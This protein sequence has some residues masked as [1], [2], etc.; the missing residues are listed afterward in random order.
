MKEDKRPYWNDPYVIKV[1]QEADHCF[2]HPLGSIEEVNS[3]NQ[4]ARSL[5]LNGKWKFH[6]SKNADESV[7]KFYKSDYQCDDWDEISVPANWQMEGYGIP[8]YINKTYP[9]PKR[10]P[11]VDASYNPVGQYFRTFEI[12]DGWS[13]FKIFLNLEG[14]N[15]SATIWING[16]EVGYHQDSKTRA[17]FYITP[18]LK[19]GVNEIAIEVYRWCDGSYLE[20]QDFWRL[21]G[22]ERPIYLTARPKTYIQDYKISTLLKEDYKD[23]I[24]QAD[25]SLA[26]KT[27]L[28][29]ATYFVKCALAD[30]NNLMA[31]ALEEV[32]FEEGQIN[33]IINLSFPVTDP[34]KWTAETPELYDVI[35]SLYNG[36]NDQIEC[37]KAKVGFRSVEIKDGV[38]LV[39]GEYVILKGVNHHEH[40][41]DHGH[42]ISEASMIEDIL[43]MKK[44]NINAVRNSH[45]PKCQRWYELCDVYGL[46]IVDEANIEAHA[47]GARFQDEYDESEHTSNLIAFKEAH[48][49]RVK[50]MYHR[51]KN[52]AS[53]IIW[54]LG[55]EAGNGPNHMATYDWLKL[56]DPY[57][58]I[59]Y[60]QA[61]EDRNTDIV[62]PMYP[63][64]EEVA[65]YATAEKHR[66]YIMC[67]YSHAMGNSLGNFAEY[68][69]LI[70]K[71]R[72]LQGGFIWDWHDQGIRA[73]DER[74]KKY[75]KFGGDYGDE[76]VPSDGNFCINGLVFP[77]RTPHPHLLE[78]KQLYQHLHFSVK[79][80]TSGQ[81]T[82]TNGYSFLTLITLKVTYRIWTW[83]GAK[84]KVLSYEGSV[85]LSGFAP[86][87]KREFTIQE[88]ENIDSKRCW[89]VDLQAKDISNEP[90]VLAEEQFQS[91][92]ENR[93]G[94]CDTSKSEVDDDLSIKVIEGEADF[95]FI[96][97]GKCEVSIDRQT[98]YL[99][100]WKYEEESLL[101]SPLRLNFWRA[102]VDNDFGWDMPN[103]CGKWRYAHRFFEVLNIQKV[104][105]QSNSP[106]FRVTMFNKI[107]NTNVQLTYHIINT[108]KISIEVHCEIG[109]TNEDD[110]IPRIG[111]TT[112]VSPSFQRVRWMGRGPHEN[113]SDR[114]RSAH[115]GIY[116]SEISAMH[117]PYISAQENGCRTDVYWCAL[118]NEKG[119]VIRV[120]GDQ[121][122]DMTATPYSSEALT[123]GDQHQL[124]SVELADSNKVSLSL[125]HL[126]MGLGGID[127]WGARPLDQYIIGPG[128][129]RFKFDLEVR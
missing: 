62:C 74:G 53:V 112:E 114:N 5:S 12:P 98:G 97:H 88:L 70:Y 116:E 30:G 51:S 57:R 27:D 40:D 111:L 76:A 102:P 45:Y 13:E 119:R 58:P 46:Y 25:V 11:Y 93:V 41:E 79:D 85:S 26:R 48:L 105:G 127:S 65:A 120:A 17:E 34:K 19:K 23:A 115:F 122:F 10:P 32:A 77:D 4:P 94:E 15:S 55:N 56:V 100:S 1:G 128:S 29:S 84:E 68:W 21:S 78:V 20:C 82:I 113:Y 6:W 22:I 118:S 117:E 121:T 43:L 69:D 39:N 63:T 8:I 125:D 33:R 104:E 89:F 24:F 2:L 47:M 42:V 109:A 35:I 49:L 66:P 124:K 107:I 16:E 61:G 110:V 60:E 80:W 3:K 38:L 123:R 126:Q 44:N 36:S 108:N 96:A 67:E 52:H 9:F 99:K 87:E 75:W 86:K 18:F 37:L 71:Y 54:S 83:D 28:F 7:Q 59:Q 73:L 103:I 92:L 129:Y 101:E 91:K 31:T 14:V 50:S 90:K 95:R 72:L 106:V 64:L 81:V